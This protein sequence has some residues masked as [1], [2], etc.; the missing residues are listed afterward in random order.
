MISPD[1]DH[2]LPFDEIHEEGLELKR[3]LSPVKEI[4]A[5]YQLLWSVVTE[6]A[7][8][9][10]CFFKGS[11]VGMD[12]SCY[13]VSQSASRSSSACFFSFSVSAFRMPVV[14]ASLSSMIPV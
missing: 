8:F 10:K 13:V 14:K 1:E 2:F 12:V 9:L 7:L 4:S 5:D 11:E 3:L 6:I